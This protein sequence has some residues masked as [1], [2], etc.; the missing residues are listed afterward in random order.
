[1][2]ELSSPLALL[3]PLLALA[4]AAH[5]A[6]CDI[7]DAASPPTPCVAAHSTTRAL[8]GSY[9]GPLYQVRRASDRRDLDIHPGAPGGF[10]DSATQDKFCAAAACHIWLIYDQS[11]RHNHLHIAPPG[12]NHEKADAPVN[13]TRESLLV[14]GHK[15]YAAVFEGGMGYRRDNT[16]STATVCSCHHDVVC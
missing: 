6:P 9:T 14:G 7:L 13:A 12:G 8:Y 11:P 2:A 16:V 10:A 5:A 4:A 15:V 3:A 1:M